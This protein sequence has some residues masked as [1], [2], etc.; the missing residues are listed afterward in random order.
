MK[1]LYIA[2][3]GVHF[4]LQDGATTYYFEIANGSYTEDVYFVHIGE[5]GSY[6]VDQ[7][8]FEDDAWE[9]LRKVY[10]EAATIA[11]DQMKLWV[12]LM[13]SERLKLKIVWYEELITEFETELRELTKDPPRERIDDLQELVYDLSH[14]VEYVD[15]LKAAQEC[16]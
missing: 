1:M 15:G 10:E 5:E 11:E 16:F 4:R 7:E 12:E 6:T 13:P 9:P 2:D 14:L 8:D 3:G